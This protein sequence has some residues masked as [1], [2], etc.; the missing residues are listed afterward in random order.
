MK[1]SNFRGK[2]RENDSNERESG[3]VRV[4]REERGARGAV[5][6]REREQQKMSTGSS[7]KRYAGKMAACEMRVSA[8]RPHHEMTT[9]EEE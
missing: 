9:R 6:K 8:V 2:E 1:V 7:C 5:G 4:R 3:G